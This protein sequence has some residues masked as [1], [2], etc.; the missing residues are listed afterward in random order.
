MER[1]GQTAA[2]QKL[3][4][5]VPRSYSSAIRSL[6]PIC[7]WILI[8]CLC[9]WSPL[10]T[11]GQATAP[12]AA[13]SPN[14]G[15]PA[16]TPTPN[17]TA[18]APT[19]PSAEETKAFD[20]ARKAFQ[21]GAY[22][23]ANTFFAEFIQQFPNS[24]R[25]PEAWLY[26][27]RSALEQNRLAESLELLNGHLGSSGKVTDEYRYWL[28]E[29]HFRKNEFAEAAEQFER[30]LK[31]HPTSTRRLEAAYGEARAHFKQ[32][33]WAKVVE[34]LRPPQSA[35]QQASSTR[36]NDELVVAGNLILIEAFLELKNTPAAVDIAAALSSKTFS[37]EMRWRY[38][39]TL[40]KIFLQSDQLL[41][42]LKQ[43]TNAVAAAVATGI[44]SST[45]E[46]ISMQASI[47]SRLNRLDEAALAYEQNLTPGTPIARQREALAQVLQIRLQQNQLA[48]V[49][50]KLELV[51]ASPMAATNRDIY[52]LT[53][54]ETLL[55]GYLQF[56]GNATN[57]TTPTPE[58]YTITNRLTEAL[59]RFDEL[60]RSQPSSPLVGLANL[61]R[62]WCLWA[63]DRITESQEAFRDA[64]NTLPLSEDQAVAR[65]K[66]GECQFRSRDYTNALVS[67]GTFT[68]QYFALPRIKNSLLDQALIYTIR[69]DSELGDV[70]GASQALERL[71]AWKPDSTFVDSSL[72]LM[73]QRLALMDDPQRARSWL[74]RV[75][76]QSPQKP[77]AELA[78]VRTYSQEG[79]WTNALSLCADWLSRFPTNE[80]LRPRAEYQLALN[81][82]R[83][84][85]ES[86]AF[87]LFTN[88]VSRYPVHSLAPFA[89]YWVG[90][91]YL[92]QQ[93]YTNAE[94]HFRR[95]YQNTNWPV[96]EIT[97]QARMQEGRAAFA[98]QGFN[99]AQDLFAGIINEKNPPFPDIVAK[100]YFAL[101]DCLMMQATLS[102]NAA[103]QYAEAAKAFRNITFL[104]G[105]N[106]VA[107]KAWG[108]L[109]NCY[110][111]LAQQGSELGSAYYNEATNAYY[112]VLNHPAS[113]VS[114]RSQAEV[115]VGIVL[116]KI[117]DTLAAGRDRQA[118][119]DRSQTHFLKVLYEKNL[120]LGQ[121][122]DPAWQ[123]RAGIEAAQL[124]EAN[125]DWK[126]ALSIYE[127][128]KQL[129]PPLA[130]DLDRRIL[131]VK[132]LLGPDAAK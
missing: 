52:L 87:S 107:P 119:L 71:L 19:A 79:L 14:A 47:L 53:Y 104:Y 22:A 123:K 67:F 45:A 66:L 85:Q 116:R 114:D 35:F 126:A 124:C 128:L 29:A 112:Q 50:Q 40:C 83:S 68:N 27:G 23:T 96:S 90:D 60:L 122:P 18:P 62:G 100:A 108:N 43:S 61:Y 21:D 39:Q 105:T 97:Y 2:L 84:G 48:V 89:Q 86:N 121:T 63:G 72:L 80:E 110:L 17:A 41:S 9:L 4:N 56:S 31:D 99:N 8:G 78:V 125:Q 92:H 75:P 70:E 127:R 88:F 11:L 129:L 24:D 20:A 95:L 38:E 33:H 36:A 34:L 37:P 44:P 77:L 49:T 25:I 12:A 120:I 115:G 111:Q 51:L 16:P 5:R 113:S 131:R 59:G 3:S 103:A 28:A 30:L 1:Y 46:S 13:P 98:R 106:N 73:G 93:D 58:T 82:Y 32:G 74:R 69:I 117:A 10:D 15:T 76:D 118:L 102:T 130:P 26:R 81:T 54:G 91:Y 57:E 94:I 7:Y 64:V 55:R 6:A 42:A 65:F 109:A 132:T 101:G